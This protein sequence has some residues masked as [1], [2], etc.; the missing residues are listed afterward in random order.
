MTLDESI[1][2]ILNRTGRRVSQ[3]LA[4]RLAPY[5]VTTEQWS[6]LARLNEEGT[7]T[8]KELAYRVGK[9]QTNVTRILDQLERK[10]LVVRTANPED[11]RSYL[12]R[13]TAEGKRLFEQLRPIEQ[14]TVRLAAEGLSDGELNE[15]KRLLRHIERNANARL[16]LADEG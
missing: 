10:K 1:G 12:P 5:D 7:M 16:G 6:V 9:D 13:I 2:F 8:Q 11:R 4:L 15:L 3:L 14:E